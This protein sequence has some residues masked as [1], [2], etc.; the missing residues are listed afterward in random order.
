MIEKKLDR[1]NFSTVVGHYH[2]HKPKGKSKSDKKHGILSALSLLAFLFFLNILQNCIREQN[3][4]PTSVMMLSQ[5]K[6]PMT[7][8]EYKTVAKRFGRSV[9][10]AEEKEEQITNKPEAEKGNTRKSRTLLQVMTNR[11]EKFIKQLKNTT[12][13]TNE[14]TQVSEKDLEE[15]KLKTLNFPLYWKNNR[16]ASTTGYW[17]REKSNKTGENNKFGM[18]TRTSFPATVKRIKKREKIT[19]T[20]PTAESKTHDVEVVTPNTPNINGQYKS[21]QEEIQN[22][23][24]AEPKQ[25]EQKPQQKPWL[26]NKSA[27]GGLKRMDSVTVAMVTPQALTATLQDDTA[28]TPRIRRSDYGG[29]SRIESYNEIDKSNHLEEDVPTPSIGV[30]LNLNTYQT[31]PIHRYSNHRPVPA[32]ENQTTGIDVYTQGLMADL[33][34]SYS[35]LTRM[36]TETTPTYSQPVPSYPK[37]PYY[38]KVIYR[39]KPLV[40]KFQKRNEFPNRKRPFR[41]NG[42]YNNHHDHHD[43][44]LEAYYPIVVAARDPDDDS[45]LDLINMAWNMVTSLAKPLSKLVPSF[46]KDSQD[47]SQCYDLMVCEAQRASK[48]MGPTAETVAAT[49]GTV[50]T[51]AVTEETRPLIVEAIKSG[52]ENTCQQQ[53]KDCEDRSGGKSTM[54]LIAQLFELKQKA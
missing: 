10:F 27:D 37:Q 45:G 2:S 43:H 23:K 16:L 51:W 50:L 52:K 33:T 24:Y 41:K 21:S 25:N 9:D 26:F 47:E 35:D 31:Y 20:D 49:V 17:V 19:T 40:Y 53:I 22:G 46:G 13:W 54:T 34:T 8:E 3:Q 42:S 28:T 4:E 1:Y 38:G 44:H 30:G 7:T 11:Q 48:F 36:T 29:G 32:R 18:E 15:Q 6:T 14:L 12:N 39:N 5:G